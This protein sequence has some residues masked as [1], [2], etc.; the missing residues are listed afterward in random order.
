ME[1]DEFKQKV[2]ESGRKNPLDTIFDFERIAVLGLDAIQAVTESGFKAVAMR[3]HP[4][5]GGD[6]EYFVA[7]GLAM[8]R[9]RRNPK[10]ALELY[11]EEHQGLR[12]DENQT[13]FLA[14]VKKQSDL[15]SATLGVVTRKI[16]QASVVTQ[17]WWTSTPGSFDFWQVG[18]DRKTS[19]MRSRY[20]VDLSADRFTGAYYWHYKNQEFALSNRGLERNNPC[21]LDLEWFKSKGEWCV[22]I[23]ANDK[24]ISRQEPYHLLAKKEPAQVYVLGSVEMKYVEAESTTPDE[25]I[26]ESLSGDVADAI[27]HVIQE[28]DVSKVLLYSVPQFEEGNYLIYTRRTGYDFRLYLSWRPIARGGVKILT[29]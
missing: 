25:N 7:I 28:E 1:F 8:E 18:P 14:N 19:I 23:K 17:N 16:S 4:D 3:T 2:K 5:L 24:T 29:V 12:V 13:A 9:F 10:R 6:I 27:G 22:R 26:Q 21:S 11:L 15:L 20:P